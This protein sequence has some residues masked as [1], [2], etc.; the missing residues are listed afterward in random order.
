[1]SEDHT[2]KTREAPIDDAVLDQT[3]AQSEVDAERIVDALVILHA[4][5]VGRH[6]EFER[7][8]DYVTVDNTRAYRVPHPV[9]D[10]L[11]D[12]FEFE[13]AVAAAVEFAHTEQARRLFA[14]ADG[15]EE[16]FGDDDR[17]V[18]IGIDTAEVF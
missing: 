14:D 9:W 4:E 15:V 10:D 8:D 2:S 16:R 6:A 3:A 5:L 18:V 11:I 13:A 17:G 12:A 1:M 7:D